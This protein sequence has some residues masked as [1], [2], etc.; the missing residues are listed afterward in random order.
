MIFRLIFQLQVDLYI[1]VYK[2]IIIIIVIL[3]FLSLIYI[4]YI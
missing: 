2:Y 3:D 4:D 1:I